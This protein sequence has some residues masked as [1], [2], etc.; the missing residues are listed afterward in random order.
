[1]VTSAS[2]VFFLPGLTEFTLTQMKKINPSIIL[3]RNPFAKAFV[4]F[5]KTQ[6][7]TQL[8][9]YFMNIIKTKLYANLKN[10]NNKNERYIRQV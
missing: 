7:K 9:G 1:M 5:V 3:Y 4:D 10:K 2:G 6:N 8:L